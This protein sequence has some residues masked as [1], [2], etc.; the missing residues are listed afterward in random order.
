MSA[1]LI[2]G[3]DRHCRRDAHQSAV[4]W[5]D[6]TAPSQRPEQIR[7]AVQLFGT[8]REHDVLRVTLNASVY[9][10]GTPPAQIRPKERLD[11]LFQL[12]KEHLGD[13]LPY[14]ASRGDMLADKFGDVLVRTIR[15]AF[16]TVTTGEP[17]PLVVN[18][19]ADGLHRMLTITVIKTTDAAKLRKRL[20]STPIE[21]V[22]LDWNS[23]VLRLP[24]LSQLERARIDEQ[25]PPE[26]TISAIDARLGNFLDD[27]PLESTKILAEYARFRSFYPAFARIFP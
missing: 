25:L 5:L 2:T 6:Y 20:A 21:N 9:T 16:A 10:L 22:P 14:D 17:L 4:V 19:Y 15:K 26:T 13:L 23:Q 24:E 18:E 3:F 27:D 11:Y 12:L 8:L 1:D 7:E